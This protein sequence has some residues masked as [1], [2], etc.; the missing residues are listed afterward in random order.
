MIRTYGEK[1]YTNFCSL[2]VQEVGVECASVT[3]ISIGSLL[4]YQSKVYL[5]N[6]TYKIV[7]I[8]YF[9]GSIFETDEN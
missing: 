1:V 8:N 6:Y 9:D 2:N 5:E 7:D 3:V 4:V